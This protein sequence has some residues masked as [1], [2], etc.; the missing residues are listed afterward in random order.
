[1]PTLEAGRAER[2]SQFWLQTLVKDDPDALNEA[3][4][5][6]ASDLS[7]QTI[8]WVSPL[9]AEDYREYQDQAFLA[10]LGL[11]PNRRPLEDF[12]P[13]GGPVWDGLARTSGGKAEVL[14][15][16][17]K[18]HIRE[19][20]SPPSRASAQ[21]LAKIRT[22]LDE[23]KKYL[24]GNP[25]ADWAGTFY[26]VT[27]RLAHLYFLRVLNKIP[28][29]LVF[30]YFVG[31]TEMNGP[32]TVDE[33]RGAVKAIETYLGVERNKLSRF[34]HHVYFDVRSL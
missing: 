29:H 21:S 28:A 16:E 4:L 22:S 17:A 24:N 6:E 7:G 23:T 11:S 25:D 18:S 19:A 32:E 1:M 30:L 9:A 26:Q 14:L 3:I 34:V 8:A 12:W 13:K 20:V 15:V 2:G 10:K 5:A 31:D 33:W 27:N